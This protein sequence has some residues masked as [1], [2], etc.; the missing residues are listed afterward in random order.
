MN[1]KNRIPK[2]DYFRMRMN[3]ATTLSK[4]EYYAGRLLDMGESLS[5]MP[6]PKVAA[7][8]WRVLRAK[9]EA[10]TRE[11]KVKYVV[12]TLQMCDRKGISQGYA[13]TIMIHTL[14]IS[15]DVYLEGLNIASGG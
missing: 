15:Q 1:R 5:S 3:N 12:S 6:K 7:K 9:I 4:R 2:A 13:H 11:G 10:E 8:N 14:G